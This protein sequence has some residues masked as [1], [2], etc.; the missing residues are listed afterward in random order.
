MEKL[1][2]TE[3]FDFVSETDK[4]F[5]IAFD[6]EMKK[7][8]YGAGGEI[9]SGYCWGKYMIIYRKLNV[10]SKKVYARIYLKNDSIAMRLYLSNID[11]HRDYIENAP[12]YVKEVF[13]GPEGDCAHCHNEKNGEC[14]FRKTYTI[15]NKY[16]EKCNGLTFEFNQPKLNKLYDYIDLFTE[17]N[18]IK[19]NKN[20]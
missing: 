8:G 14:K 2:S 4:A 19:K 1:L 9:V 18:S 15:D 10:K 11:E 5:I 16:I 20:T 13:V 12:V 7:L 6:N 3:N 17:F